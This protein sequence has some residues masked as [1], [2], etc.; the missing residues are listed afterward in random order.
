MSYSEPEVYTDF[1]HG[2]HICPE[3]YAKMGLT[4][5]EEQELDELEERVLDLEGP[6]D[7]EDAFEELQEANDR[8][9][10]LQEKRSRQQECGTTAYASELMDEEGEG[11]W[12]HRCGTELAEE[13]AEYRLA[14]EVKESDGEIVGTIDKQGLCTCLGCMREVEANDRRIFRPEAIGKTC[15]DCEKLLVPFYKDRTN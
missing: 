6:T 10:E 1:E 11:F 15:W 13:T 2:E 12:C 3:C 5:E 14:R 8:I 7:E 9:G 4:P